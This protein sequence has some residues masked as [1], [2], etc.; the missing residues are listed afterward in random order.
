MH[1]KQSRIRWTTRSLPLWCVIRDGVTRVPLPGIG[2]NRSF[3]KIRRYQ[4]R[5]E[6]NTQ[7]CEASLTKDGI[8]SDQQLAREGLLSPRIRVRSV[9]SAWSDPF[10][11]MY[12]LAA[13]WVHHH[14]GT[15]VGSC[16][17]NS[18][19]KRSISVFDLL[20]FIPQLTNRDAYL[21]FL[22]K[23]LVIT[24]LVTNWKIASGWTPGLSLSSGVVVQNQPNQE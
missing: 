15:P 12:S 20:S 14:G 4:K 22:W 9:V 7:G 23:D 17:L 19:W 8:S 2:F 1:W 10:L 11:G 24:F 21:Y 13:G 6:A 5:Q 3:S 16:Q 18:G